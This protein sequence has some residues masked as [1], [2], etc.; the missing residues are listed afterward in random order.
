[1]S[2]GLIAALSASTSVT[3]TPD[4]NA[5][6]LI[7]GTCLTT[8]G[9]ITVNSIGALYLPSNS[10]NSITFYAAVGMPVTIATPANVTAIVSSLEES[11]L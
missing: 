1:M 9:T 5:K 3:F 4:Y 11:L 10:S 7:N 2:T 6:V 8:A